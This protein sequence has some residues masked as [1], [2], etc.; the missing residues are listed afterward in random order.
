MNIKKPLLIAGAI[1]TIGFAGLA[2]SSLA[3]AQSSTSGSDSLVSKIAQKFNLKTEDVQAVFTEDRNAREAEHQAS[4]EKELTQAVT[5]GKITAD[6]KDKIVA[7]QKE[8]QTSMEANRDA[9]KDKT[10]AERKAAMDA[11]RTELE[12]WAKDNNIP[13][14]FLRYVHGGHGGPGG[15]GGPHGM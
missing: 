12:Q 2:G 14:E 4:I 15:P 9:M 7:K 1:S 5:D 3:S 11:K 10:E 8:L 6:Q 13:T